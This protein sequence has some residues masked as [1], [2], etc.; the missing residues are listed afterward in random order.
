VRDRGD[1]PC[2]HRARVIVR[3]IRDRRPPARAGGLR[4]DLA[5]LR[6]RTE[7]EEPD[8]DRAPYCHIIE[9]G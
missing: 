3:R 4:D 1:R 6:I 7:R 2:D 8:D 9:T 5:E